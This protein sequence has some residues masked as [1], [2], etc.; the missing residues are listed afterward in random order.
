MAVD[1]RVVR[2]N[3]TES[4][5][6]YVCK[7]RGGE[8]RKN[9]VKEIG[10][11]EKLTILESHRYVFTEYKYFRVNKTI[12]PVSAE[13]GIRQYPILLTS[14]LVPIHTAEVSE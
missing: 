10:K 13:F 7:N 2:Q 6:K 1:S 4:L 9:L 14:P 8:E 3:Q 12:N 5:Y 11:E